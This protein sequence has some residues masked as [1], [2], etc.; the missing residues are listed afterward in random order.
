MPGVQADPG[1]ERYRGKCL[2]TDCRRRQRRPSQ[3]AGC[4]PMSSV[5]GFQCGE[6]TPRIAE[7]RRFDDEVSRA[8]RRP[9]RHSRARKR[10]IGKYLAWTRAGAGHPRPAGDATP[11]GSRRHYDGPDIVLPRR[12]TRRLEVYGT[13]WWTN[14][15]RCTSAPH[16][17]AS[18]NLPITMTFIGP[19][20]R[21]T[22]VN[23]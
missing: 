8:R 23:L 20:V 7:A 21:R 10:G 12:N 19:G 1:S 3:S 15:S 2:P 5:K 16:F 4:V 17:L 18:A 13:C 11:G 6:S 22:D 9:L 14:S